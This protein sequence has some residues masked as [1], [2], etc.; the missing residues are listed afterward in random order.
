M[1][2][3]REDEGNLDE[4]IWH[5][6]RA[7]EAQP[8]NAAIQSELQR[9]YG[10]RDGVTPP[11][12]RMT[13]GALAHMYMQGELYPQAISETRAVLDEDRHPRGKRVQE[14]LGRVRVSG[15]G[16]NRLT[17]GGRRGGLIGLG[18]T[19]PGVWVFK[20][21][22]GQ[23]FRVFP[24]TNYTLALGMTTALAVGVLAGRTR[25]SRCRIR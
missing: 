12:I 10:R 9:L 19:F 14:R 6:E 11:R 7:F 20:T 21:K 15:W 13:R 22:L 2:I 5:M 3:I 16:R 23:Y 8:S 1:S 17:H 25:R 4:A 24:L 18:L